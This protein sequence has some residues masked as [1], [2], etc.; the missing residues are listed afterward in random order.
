[1]F[2]RIPTRT[3]LASLEQAER[4]ELIYSAVDQRLADL[5]R[6]KLIARLNDGRT[7]SASAIPALRASINRLITRAT[8]FGITVEVRRAV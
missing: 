6:L 7:N 3:E 2:D 4:E 8:E 5:M 1:M